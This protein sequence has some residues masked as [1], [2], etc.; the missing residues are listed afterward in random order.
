MKNATKL[1]LSASVAMEDVESAC[2]AGVPGKTRAQTSWS[3]GVWVD[4]A[5]RCMKLP[6]ADEQESQ[7][8][9]LKDF[10]A[11]C[12]ESMKCRLCKFV[13]E[14]RRVDGENYPPDSFYSICSGLNRSLKFSDSAEINLL[15]DPGFSCFRHVLDAG[16]KRLRSTGKYHKKTAMVIG[17]EEETILW[18]KGF[19]GDHNPQ[20]LI[21]TLMYY[22]VLCFA[23]HGGEHCKLRHNPSQI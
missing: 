22:I 16:I 15:S 9:L 11:M 20:A 21:D 4:R 1:R 2:V 6:A 17:M 5:K 3:T 12:V 14:V 19:L 7:Y 10:S 13:F 8:E 18:E 23:I